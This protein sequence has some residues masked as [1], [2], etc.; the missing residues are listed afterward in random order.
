MDMYGI[1]N[2]DTV[3]KARRWLKAHQ[4]DYAFH[5]YKKEGVDAERLQAWCEQVGWE[6]LLN[7]RG[8][9]WRKLSQE[10]QQN[11]N[12]DKAL[13]LLQAYPSMIKRPILE[14]DGMICVGFSEDEYARFCGLRA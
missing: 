1:P 8:M 3:R 5:D 6:V 7:R 13:A 9:T 4:V 2:C 10:A 12:Q 14:R 11:L